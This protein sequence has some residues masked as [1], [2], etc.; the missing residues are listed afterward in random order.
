MTTKKSKIKPLNKSS[1]K[2]LDK[3]SDKSLD[4]SLD[5]PLGNL[6]DGA[7]TPSTTTVQPPKNKGGQ[8]SK[9]SKYPKERQEVLDKLFSI[10]QVTKDNMSFSLTDLEKDEAKQKQILDL[11]DDI[12]KYFNCGSWPYFYKEKMTEPYLSLSKSLLKE[13]NYKTEYFRI[14]DSK[15]GKITA[16][17]IEIVKN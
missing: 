8:P 14:I 2:P 3:P 9:K 12:K 11:A 13:M 1:D 6:L 17:K 10:L 7:N 15:S 4:K 16:K 5:K